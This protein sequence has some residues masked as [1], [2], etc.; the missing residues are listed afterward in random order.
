MKG[1]KYLS[2]NV[3]VLIIGAG[4]AGLAIGYY[5]SQS[6]QSFILIDAASR[7]GDVWRNRYD[8]LVL[9]SPRKYSS[10]S[11]LAMPGDSAVYPTKDEFADYLEAY[12]THFSLPIHLNTKVKKLIQADDSFEVSTSRGRYTA[13][14][15][16]IATGPFQ[17]PFI[18]QLD[19]PGSKSILQL[20]SSDYRGPYQ[21]APGP[22]LVVGGGNSGA[23]IA[24]ELAQSR[25]VY[26][27]AGHEMVFI[28]R[29][30]LKRS[31]FWWLDVTRLARVSN[32]S[33]LAK[34]LKKTEPVIG[35]ELKPFLENGKVIV[36]DRAVSLQDQEVGFQDGAKISVSNIIWATGFRFDYSWIDIPGVLDSQGKPIHQQGLSPVTGVYFLGL[37][38]LS[39]VGSAQIN[40]IN[41]DAK[42]IFINLKKS[43][44]GH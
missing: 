30:I 23:Q 16:V 1:G 29:E 14:K 42:K 3:D 15:V 10:L 44:G 33:K 13:Q 25:K 17:K 41:Y 22:A 6:N 2:K 20:H 9:F 43:R 38:W 7:V 5:L 28:P 21:L 31:I 39:R 26:L 35:M 36:K 8:S 11:G 34:L 40:G 32:G 37:P 19:G 27:S 12:A 4:Q 18:P 24:L